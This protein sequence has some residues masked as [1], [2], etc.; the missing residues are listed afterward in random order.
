MPYGEISLG[1]V[2]RRLDRI[3]SNMA[4]LV[5]RREHTDLD[6]RVAKVESVLDKLLMG[7]VLAM[8]TGAIGL[9]FVTRG[10]G[11]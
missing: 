10:L 4:D 1:E 8:L 9:L 5:S 3:E 11:G 7:V 6:R 2:I